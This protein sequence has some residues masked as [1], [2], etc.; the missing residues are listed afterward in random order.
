MKFVY[1]IIL[2]G[3]PSVLGF[4]PTTWLNWL[5]SGISFQLPSGTITH[6]AMTENAIL[7]LV[8]DVF[9]DNPNSD[10][11]GSTQRIESL[12]DIDAS[13]LVKAYY[14]EKQRSITN[15]LEKAIDA[16]KDGNANVDLKGAEDKLAEAHFDS[17]RFQDGQNR[18]V[19]LRENVVSSIRMKNF[20]MARR[21]TGRLLHTLQD[22]YSHSNWVENGN[23]D[24]YRVLGRKN[25]R[26][27]PVADVS[28]QTC[29][30][31]E[32]DG[33]VILG[34]IIGFVKRT[35]NAKKFYS[36]PDNFHGFLKQSRILTSGYYTGSLD[37]NGDTIVKPKLKCSHGGF[38]DSTSDKSAKGGI[39][40]DSL[41]KKW[42]PHHYQHT[43]AARLAEMASLDILQEIRM[44]VNDDALFSQFLGISVNVI[45]ASIAYV[46]DTT[47]GM[48]DELPEIQATIPQLR[49]SLQQYAEMNGN[50]NIRYILVP[51]NDPGIL[52]MSYTICLSKS[53]S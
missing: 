3:V 34:R 27:D 9:I 24:I 15:N 21:D 2:A 26:P 28:L 39:N 25:Q 22:F 32:K 49:T 38:L 48:A 8:R 52:I 4:V 10:N 51:F 19:M 40:K 31:C 17:E 1:L 43:E 36:C 7:Q 29:T 18:L 30:D 42:S 13:N 35:N 37:S 50:T 33:T 47:A 20:D 41:S 44:D 14:G 12:D 23:L 45:S 16:I 6:G 11:A 53:T 5:V 46:I